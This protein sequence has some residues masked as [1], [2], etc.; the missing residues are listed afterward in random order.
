MTIH[1]FKKNPAAETVADEP[2]EGM[3]ASPAALAASMLSHPVGDVPE[4]TSALA[5]LQGI[6][7]SLD[8]HDWTG[9]APPSDQI[10]TDDVQNILSFTRATLNMRMPAAMRDHMQSKNLALTPD[11]NKALALSML[12]YAIAVASLAPVYP[13]VGQPVDVAYTIH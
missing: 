12:D 8:A 5:I 10:I 3:Q 11:D 1:Q 13:D 2:Q 7:A 4:D 9:E 6:R